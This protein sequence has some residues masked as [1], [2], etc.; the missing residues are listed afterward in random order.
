MTQQQV[1]EVL[2]HAHGIDESTLSRGLQQ[3]YSGALDY[4]DIY[5]QHSVHE[6]WMLEDGIVK[7]GSYT[8]EA[9]LGVRAVTGEKT[10]FAYADSISEQSLL[11]AARAARGITDAGQERQ[12][13]ILTATSVPPLYRQDDPLKSLSE[14]KKIELLQQMDKHARKIDSKVVEVAV[15]LTGVWEHILVAATDGTLA[16]DIRPLVRLNCTVLVEQE[17]RRE[18]G[19]AGG[20]GR[21]DYHYFLASEQGSR[22]GEKPRY[23]AYVEEAVRQA[24]V[25]LDARAAPAGNLPVVLGNGWPGVLLHEAVGHGLE[26]DFN[27]KGASAY[28]NRMGEIVA[29]KGCTIVDDGTIANRR[30]SLSVDD[31]GTPS[32]Y[33]VLIEDGRLVG[34]M[35]DK[36]NARLMGVA[37][38]G[39]GRRES[40]AHL[41][42]PRMTNTYMLGGDYPRD[43]IIASVKKGIYAPQFSGGQVDI[44]SGKFVFTA[45][46]AYLI[47]DGKIT[48]PI[49]GVTL[50]GNG[51]EAMQ[52]V[53]MV[54]NDLDLDTGIGV[55]GKD[56]QSVPVGVG[57]PTLK[58]DSMTIGGTD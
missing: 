23:L 50:I 38:T 28:S 16:T 21:V 42:M 55:C 44:T 40:Y 7:N 2:L 41:P 33:N 53:S 32:A 9:G 20:G 45:S 35:Q 5:L 19:S 26:G 30:G 22:G 8:I 51:P 37:P 31:E 14:T 48:A 6:A 58:I 56:G 57:Q 11:D 18:R 47:E 13:K 4:A 24:L 54:G 25:M 34:Y 1:N 49:K 15:S 29:S 52:R 36:M 27:R 10:G 43:E 46:E 17:G 39:N 12:V 3:M